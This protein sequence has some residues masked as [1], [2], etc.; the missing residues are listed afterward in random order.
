MRV[1]AAVVALTFGVS[2]AAMA[3]Q[4]DPD[5][6]EDEFI[7]L[8]AGGSPDGIDV[9]AEQS[10]PVLTPG[11]SGPGTGNVAADGNP[12]DEGAYSQAAW[13]PEALP[14]D[15]TFEDGTIG[16][17]PPGVPEIAEEAE[18]EDEELTPAD[19]QA[20]ILTAFQSLPV[21]GSP[22]TYQ[23]EGDWALVNMDFIVYT[24]TATQ[25]LGTTI[26]GVPVTF[27]LTPTHWTWDFGDGATMPSS[28]PGAAYPNHTLSHVYSSAHDGVT[29]SLTTLWSG[30]FQIGG[31]GDWY[32]VDGF[33]T[34]T[35]TTGP[36]EIV[37]MDVHLVPNDT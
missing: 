22:I 15:A 36:I 32:P 12:G 21:A 1:L 4:Q 30:E 3:A 19:I 18:A 5:L 29:V 8:W 31:A 13:E 35:S 27:E 25:N 7:D 26:L 9:E 23:P 33:V 6:T 10:A 37:A 20:A 17:C 24:D 2:A 28:N 34:T 16:N 14:C 11:Y